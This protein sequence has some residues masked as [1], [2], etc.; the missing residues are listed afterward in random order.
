M[1]LTN[2]A[3]DAIETWELRSVELPHEQL[4]VFDP[5]AGQL[6]YKLHGEEDRV[7]IG[8]IP[9]PVLKSMSRFITTHNHPSQLFSSDDC[10]ANYRQSVEDLSFCAKFH[11]YEDRVV[12]QAPAGPE[13]P[14]GGGGVWVSRVRMPRGRSGKA[15]RQF[16]K[17]EQVKLAKRTG[18]VVCEGGCCTREAYASGGRRA[19]KSALFEMDDELMRRTGEEFGFEYL[20]EQIG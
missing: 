10:S 19:N 6:V 20:R 7:M 5:R 2:Q 13:S 3:R 11:P 17:D 16:V 15:I 8:A 12:F 14:A 9:F 1:P 18:F 4:C